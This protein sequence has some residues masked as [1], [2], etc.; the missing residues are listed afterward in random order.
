MNAP[1][2]VAL[3]GQ[4][5]NVVADDPTG[6]LFVISY[7]A[8]PMETVLT[9]VDQTGRWSSSARFQELDTP[10]RGHQPYPDRPEHCLEIGTGQ[11][12]RAILCVK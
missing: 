10:G 8:T 11:H 2:R 7:G 1:L 4:A 3:P 12:L 6:L 5:W 9:A